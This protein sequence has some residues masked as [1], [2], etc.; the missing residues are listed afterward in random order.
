MRLLKY[1]III[2][3]FCIFL[4][5][6]GL[7]QGCSDAGFCTI[8]GFKPHN[9][10]SLTT[11]H[12]HIKIGTFVGKAD[13]SILVYGSYL[14]YNRQ[15]SADWGLDAKLTTL[16]QYGNDIS[17]LGL[18]DIFVNVN[19]RYDEKLTFT[20]GTKTPL[21]GGNKM[22]EN[23]ALPLDYQSSLGTFDLICGIG[24]NFEKI[25]VIAAIQQPLT[26]NDNQFISG[27]YSLNSKLRT[28]QSTNKYER[29]GDILLRVSYPL[30]I[31][32]GLTCT[33]SIL[34]VYHLMNDTF[35]DEFGEKKDI[36]GS[37]G[38]TFNINAYI[39]YQVNDGNSI[40]VNIGFPVIA[41]SSRPDGLTRGFI[42]NVE[43]KFSF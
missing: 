32:S 26:Q 35:T 17:V 39:D 28:F 31:N 29:A 18:S 27:E 1:G 15:L 30:A 23:R 13:N 9:S 22:I 41:R 24:Y 3:L 34:P 42:A 12:N 36:P 37:Q 33:P 7:G 8:N 6:K 5:V 25:Q 21:S 10:D 19:Y 11:L 4:P 38:L 20:L 40:Q 16:G 43:Y 14:E 2:I